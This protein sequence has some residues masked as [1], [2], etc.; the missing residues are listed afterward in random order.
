MAQPF[1]RTGGVYGPQHF[2]GAVTNAQVTS[3]P[4][5]LH[6]VVV[7]TAG[8][9]VTIKDGAVTLAIIGAVTGTFIFDC[10]IVTGVVV[11][12][13]GTPDFTINAL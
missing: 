6:T 2:S 5:V 1:G 9:T 13:T 4:G 7:G 11:T 3:G 8:T 12:S 10:Q